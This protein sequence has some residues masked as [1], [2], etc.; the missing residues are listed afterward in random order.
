MKK[1]VF[2]L[3]FIIGLHACN[4]DGDET[5]T[6]NK[7]GDENEYL[8]HLK[9][10]KDSLSIKTSDF[11]DN[12]Q[13]VP[14]ETK[15]ECFLDYVYA[16]I[17]DSYILVQKHKHGILQFDQE[18]KFLRTL[19]DYGKGPLE[20]IKGA[21]TVDEEKQILYLSD[22]GKPDYFLRFDLHSGKYLGDLKK[23]VPGR[24]DNIYLHDNKQLLVSCSGKLGTDDH[25]YQIY[26][27]D[28]DG[29]LINGIKA[30]PNYYLRSSSLLKLPD[31]EYRYQIYDVDT[32]FSIKNEMM[33][34]YMLFDFG[35]VN[36]PS[37][38]YVGHKSMS[39]YFEVN[40]WVQFYNFYITK[41]EKHENGG[42]ST[43]GAIANY[44]LDKKSHKVYN[45]GDLFF[46]PTFHFL[47]SY[48]YQSLSIQENGKVHFAYQALDL[49]EQAEKALAN[50]EFKEPYRSQLKE[51]VGNLSENDNPVLVIGKLRR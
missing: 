37:N 41:I 11:A 42:S 51:L 1:I 12:F 44:S 35:E 5:L 2:L 43:S 31:E 49:I 34:P 10:V 46:H 48:Q 32:I 18:G 26:W 40:S 17:T 20:F 36:P 39:L 25:P 19:V 4:S 33:I 13:F 38:D 24:V 28:L 7:N 16:Y 27:Q 6:I 47:T 8:V 45:S 50:P 30:S 21:W 3:A 9:K 14:L 23:A 22:M 15:K 29:K